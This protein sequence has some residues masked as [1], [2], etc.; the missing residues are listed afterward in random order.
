[1]SEQGVSS[2]AVVHPETGDLLSAVSVTDI[3]KLVAPSQSKKITMQLGQ[4][5][6]LI[7]A[8]AGSQDGVD[9]YPGKPA[10]LT[11]GF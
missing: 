11:K 1:M 10:F 7:K 3:A 6:A 9:R 2:V 4:F 8:P 5:I